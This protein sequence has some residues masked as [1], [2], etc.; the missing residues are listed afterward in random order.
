MQT[1]TPPHR[2][3]WLYAITMGLA[4]LVLALLLDA[5]G[6]GT[7][8]AGVGSGGTGT[9]S[10]TVSGFGSTIVDG[11]EYAD[12]NATVQRLDASGV[13]Q[14]TAVQLGQ[15]VRVVYQA[16]NTAQTIEVL[17]QLVGPVTAAP[18][19]SG[20]MQ[21]LGQ[22]VRVVN[23]TVDPTRSDP[24]LLAGY[25]STS[26]IASADA[27]EVFGAWVWDGS[28]SAYVLVATRIEKRAS[29]PD[30]VQF[31][32]VVQGLSS[33]G[34]RL[35]AATGT[36]VQATALPTDLANGQVVQVWVASAVSATSPVPAS[37]VLRTETV[38]SD[39][40]SQQSLRLGGLATQY[41]AATRTVVVQGTAVQLAADVVVDT[42]ALA[43]GEFV[44]LQVQR[45]GNT[46]V[47]SAA[48]VRSGT[49]GSSDLGGTNVLMGVTSGIDWSASSVHFTLRGVDVQA[50][51]A[52][53]GSSCLGVPLASD[54]SVR[55]QGSVRVPGQPVTATTVGCNLNVGSGEVVQRQGLLL[56][57]QTSTR[58]LVLR[59]AQGDT[60]ATW[61]SHTFFAQSPDTLVGRQVQAEGLFS[62]STL[63]L[64]TLRAAP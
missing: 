62:G 4:V 50:V 15:R 44:S 57:V 19:S 39:L 47:A 37:R 61:D 5:C 6:G 14:N 55:V 54:V 27:V 58:S 1:P 31:G 51:A 32:G 2:K 21:V 36:L 20:W 41:D 25:S 7:D 60:T 16:G 24:T 63:Q 13:L 49:V 53:I 64:R 42:A 29:M 48:T 59:T 9:A 12:S 28:K 26:A 56:S 35:N 38:A 30:P 18:D 43:R 22:W 17:P 40:G 23:T 10:G 11:V 45:V 33:S 3:G 52:A 8:V 46:L 34:F